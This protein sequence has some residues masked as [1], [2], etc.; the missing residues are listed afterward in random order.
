MKKYYDILGIEIGVS[1]D[2]IK[3]AYR[4]K[5][6]EFHPDKHNNLSEG[7][8]KLA[9]Q[10]FKKITDAYE[11]I[12]NSLN[13][14]KASGNREKF[15]DNSKIFKENEFQLMGQLFTID[16]ELLEHNYF[17]KFQNVKVE[18][19]IDIAR[20]IYVNSKNF[21]R[22]IEEGLGQ[23]VD[24][25]GDSLNDY[26]KVFNHLGYTNFRNSNDILKVSE[27]RLFQR[28][29]EYVDTLE[30]EY[31]TI[32]YNKNIKTTQRLFNKEIRR[33]Y[34][35]G[36]I[37]NVLNK[38]T[39]SA[40]ASIRI[41]NLYKRESTFSELCDSIFSFYARMTEVGCLICEFPQWN[42]V[43]IPN[44][45]ERLIVKVKQNIGGNNTNLLLD[46]LKNNPYNEEVYALI[47]NKS[48][49]K[50]KEL[51]KIGNVFGIDILKMKNEVIGI[52]FEEKLKSNYSKIL[53]KNEM[54]E[55]SKKLG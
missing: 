40:E 23:V 19:A 34:D 20:K 26:V 15:K 41:S 48:F 51:E 2:E 32:I 16:S 52:I 24:F 42:E 47:L 43:T 5:A 38:A 6:K 22:F 8:K 18:K 21:D 10:E 46:A 50:D 29:Q 45:T 36:A 11:K 55:F 44:E 17:R 31:N 37:R 54:E 4:E 25:L 53:L 35:K 14:K 49:D 13:E 9:E 28:F 7:M 30:D 39:I 12:I 1:Q 3:R 27:D 33:I